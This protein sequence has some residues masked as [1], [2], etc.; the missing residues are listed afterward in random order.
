MT[1]QWQFSVWCEEFNFFFS[2]PCIWWWRACFVY[3]TFKSLITLEFE[4]GLWRWD[5]NGTWAQIG[6]W[7]GIME[8][9]WRKFLSRFADFPEFDKDCWLLVEAG[10]DGIIWYYALFMGNPKFECD[11]TQTKKLKWS[12]GKSNLYTCHIHIHPPENPSLFSICPAHF[13]T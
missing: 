2:L 7:A 12:S 5:E 6:S 1:M 11:E 8:S 4:A 10:E 3:F 13:S 9:E